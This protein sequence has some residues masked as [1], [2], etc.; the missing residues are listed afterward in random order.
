[1]PRLWSILRQK[2]ARVVA[3]TGLR[4]S[5]TLPASGTTSMDNSQGASQAVTELLADL[6][7]ALTQIS[8]EDR[9]DPR[10]QLTAQLEELDRKASSYVNSSLDFCRSKEP[11]KC[12]KD[13]TKL[14]VQAWVCAEA[15]YRRDIAVASEE[16][17]SSGL[18]IE[19]SIDSSTNGNVKATTLTTFVAP[20]HEPG[21]KPATYLIIAVRGSDCTIDQIVN[22]HGE[23]RNASIKFQDIEQAPN[24]EDQ[25]LNFQAHAGFLNS[26]RQ[27][28][29]PIS[30]QIE[31]QL[32]KCRN[33]N[34]LF[35]GHSAGGAVATLLHLTL[36]AKFVGVSFTCITFGS[37]PVAKV[38]AEPD[39]I[40]LDRVVAHAPVLNIINEFDLVSRLDRGYVRSLIQLYNSE[41]LHPTGEDG[42]IAE[43]TTQ[44]R[45]P[46]PA[47]DLQHIGS[48]VVLKTDLP[49]LQLDHARPSEIIPR[50]TA[51]RVTSESLSDL[52]FCQLL[53]HRRR[54]YQEKMKQLANSNFDEIVLAIGN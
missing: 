7:V 28:S 44:N 39:R 10:A 37:P 54:Y 29:A 30:A 50:L 33:S 26:A 5:A 2:R 8:L 52:V 19:W 42:N 35:T 4:T 45:W 34:I 47:P 12:T 48:I 3:R 11:W 32:S 21:G 49:D 22:L 18:K 1:M 43:G 16:L 9:D 40:A 15:A 13:M 41:A 20:P 24:S 23:P 53:V 36:R 17:K 38:M 27:L 6:D 31:K 51:W 46:L 14:I 25:T